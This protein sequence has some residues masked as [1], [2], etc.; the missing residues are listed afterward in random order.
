MVNNTT[1]VLMKMSQEMGN[2]NGRFDVYMEAQKTTNEALFKLIE[3]QA[4]EI[5]TLNATKN[6]ASGASRMVSFAFGTIGALCIGMIGIISKFFHIG[7][8]GAG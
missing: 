1:E 3:N 7:G 8:N 4:K 2:L 6:Q 5:K